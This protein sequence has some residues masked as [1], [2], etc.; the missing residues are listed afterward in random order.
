MSGM[1]LASETNI[2]SSPV[3][4]KDDSKIGAGQP[5][6]LTLGRRSESRNP[7]LVARPRP[8]LRER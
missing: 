1:T 5:T 7:R 3:I 8:E 2:F 6:G 4:P